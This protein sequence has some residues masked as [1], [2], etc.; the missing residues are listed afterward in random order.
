LKEDKEISIMER[1]KGLSVPGE[2]G[3]ELKNPIKNL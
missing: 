2:L 1:I 3:Y